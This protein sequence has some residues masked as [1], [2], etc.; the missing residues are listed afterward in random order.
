MTQRDRARDPP[1]YVVSATSVIYIGNESSHD[2]SDYD[3]PYE[4]RYYNAARPRAAAENSAVLKH[5]CHEEHGELQELSVWMDNEG[6]LAC[7][8]L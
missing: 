8:Y 2:P 5:T 7:A 1:V 6:R 3:D 4:R